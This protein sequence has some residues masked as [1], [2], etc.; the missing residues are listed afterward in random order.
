MRKNTRKNTKWNVL[1]INKLSSIHG[2]STFYIRQ[3]LRGD[4]NNITA[5]TIRK[6]YKEMDAKV[7][8][9]LKIN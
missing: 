8:Q 2:F 1:V 6:Q 7:E 4:R 3:C 9:A 5:D